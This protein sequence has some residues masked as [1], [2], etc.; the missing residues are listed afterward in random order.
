MTG[1]VKVLL[2]G[3]LMNWAA[4]IGLLACA[5]G[6]IP[7]AEV[8]ESSNWFALGVVLSAMALSLTYV[9]GMDMPGE[10]PGLDKTSPGA[11]SMTVGVAMLGL[12]ALVLFVKGVV[13]A[14][15]QFAG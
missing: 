5:M 14:Y 6:D 15:S 3:M 12:L 1:T 11:V 13:A 8:E 7:A 9:L 4:A 10:Y 2:L